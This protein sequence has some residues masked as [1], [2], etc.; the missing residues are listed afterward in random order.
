MGIPSY[1]SY[2]LKYHHKII[3][4]LSQHR[5]D[6][7]YID[8][9]SIIYDIVN[10]NTDNIY[11][12]V[13]N[14]I[15]FIINKLKPEFTYVAFDGVVPL[16]KMKQ[17]KQRRYKSWLTKQILHTN[18]K[19][20]TNA[21]TPGTIFMNELDEY[22]KIKFNTPSIKFSGSK[23][24]GEGEHKITE[25]L[26]KNQTNKNVMIYGLDADLIM[27]GL[28]NIQYNS[29]TYLYRETKHF[30]YLN[31]IDPNIDYIFNMNEM[32]TQ[33]SELLHLEKQKAI[34]NYCFMCFLFGNDFMP[35]FPSLNIRNSGIPYL[36]ETFTNLNINLVNGI[37]IDWAGFKKLCIA[38]SLHESERIIENV[39]WKQQLKSSPLNKEDEL[40]I[41]PIKDFERELYISLH[42]DKY[43]N[44]F[45][46]QSEE[47]P[48]TNY[49]KMLEWT[50]SYYNGVCKDY[51]LCYEFNLAPL[52][53]SIINYI[54]CF[55]EEL[56][57]NNYNVKPHI[58]SQLIYVLPYTDYSLIPI[59]TTD[60]TNKFPHLK[61]MNN[62]VYYD[63]CKYFWES[64]VEFKYV[65]LKELNL[66]LHK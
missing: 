44:V 56:V 59:D 8:A 6:Q 33:I 15:L 18:K 4:R 53:K 27:L 7:L 46:G 48:C 31:N 26:R 66:Y 51:Y 42:L 20:N 41:L 23:E 25:Y 54:P 55:N 58:L 17:Q 11:E 40:N 9:N 32:A 16:A 37:H 45:F 30:T 52:F 60:I 28:L 34:E 1:F 43:Y 64:H 61:E 39:K 35:H 5:C 21:I 10:E 3:K 57:T 65:S 38:L 13:Y 47:N 29:N 12:D 49:L 22:L 2:I 24:D 36:I 63:F 62:K 19:W 50:W 14:R